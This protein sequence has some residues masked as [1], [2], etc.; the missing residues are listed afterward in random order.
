MARAITTQIVIQDVEMVVKE[1]LENALDAGATRVKCVVED[2]GTKISVSDDGPGIAPADLECVGASHSTSKL[3]S[4]EDLRRLSTYGFRGE[5]LHAIA[6]QGVLR[7]CSRTRGAA[8]G[9]GKT[10]SYAPGAELVDA[11][12]APMDGLPEGTTVIAENLFGTL[13]V[14]RQVMRE[15]QEATHKGLIHMFTCYALAHP[16]VSFVLESPPKAPFVVSE[17]RTL[18]MRCTDLYG[19][20]LMEQMERVRWVSERQLL[21]LCSFVFKKL[22]CSIL[23]CG[24]SLGVRLS[25]AETRTFQL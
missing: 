17:A 9:W 2:C 4:L 5:G 10:V 23:Q 18:E 12:V 24:R 25:V 8:R 16:E 15:R 22:M 7:V 19:P 14:R 21:F 20:N 1:L 13:P 11:P 3:S 6:S